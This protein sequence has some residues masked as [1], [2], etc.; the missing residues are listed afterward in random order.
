MLEQQALSRHS[1]TIKVFRVE[2]R[3]SEELLESGVPRERTKP[4]TGLQ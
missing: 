3:R 1:K 2:I 4:Q